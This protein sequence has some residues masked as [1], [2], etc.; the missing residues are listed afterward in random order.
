ME[1]TI[2]LLGVQWNVSIALLKNGTFYLISRDHNQLIKRPKF[3][4]VLYKFSYTSWLLDI[5]VLH[6][7]LC[8]NCFTRD[9]I[10]DCKS[11]F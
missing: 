3:N 11:S 1:K 2:A 10:F 4:E 6:N 5:I 9:L 7:I 8:L